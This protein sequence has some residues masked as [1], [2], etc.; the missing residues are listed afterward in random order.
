[1]ASP[2]E[3]LRR[4]EDGAT[5]Y[6]SEL[7]A[8]PPRM[9][10]CYLKQTDDGEVLPESEVRGRFEN[11][12]R[13]QPNMAALLNDQWPSGIA[14]DFSFRYIEAADT[15]LGAAINT[16]TL[17]AGSRQLRPNRRLFDTRTRADVELNKRVHD[18]LRG[19]K[20][21]WLKEG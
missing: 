4:F 21:R 19:L 5:I 17:Q 14:R 9:Q 13:D 3:M 6:M 2:Q 16:R 1:M 12:Y 20:K 18:A 8:V 10:R 11:V 7:G 15:A